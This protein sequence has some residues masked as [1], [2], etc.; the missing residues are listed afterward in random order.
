MDKI[1]VAYDKE[2]ILAKKID[3]SWSYSSHLKGTNPISI[4]QDPINPLLIYCGTFDRG[5]WRSIDGGNSWEAVGTRFYYNEPFDSED[6]HLSAIT[7]VFVKEDGASEDFGTVY[8]GTEPSA[9]FVSYDKGKSFTLLTDYKQFDSRKDWFFP[10]RPH[11][12]HVKWMEIDKSN[13]NALFTTIEAGGLIRSID[14]GSSWE[15]LKKDC[16]PIDIH[17]LRSHVLAPRRLYGI[18]GDHFLEKG[19]GTYVESTNGG[20]SW[21]DRNNGLENH[22][23]GYHLAVHSKNPDCIIVA[24]AKDPY[25]AHVYSDG[26]CESTLYRIDQ[27]LDCWQEIKVGLPD[28]KGTLISA[29]H[30][31]NEIFIAANNKGVFYS[32]DNGST[33]SDTFNIPERFKDQHAHDV[34]ILH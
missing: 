18:L 20:I 10:P 22:P 8:V 28:P 29:L 21:Q 14:N 26:S 12:H 32:K 3:N 33:W 24:V 13:P 27:H 30:A 4:F 25:T 7:T 15:E 9:L 19:R 16:Y 17:V 6:I 2:V 5:L 11:T 23:Y 1:I 31:D 34:K